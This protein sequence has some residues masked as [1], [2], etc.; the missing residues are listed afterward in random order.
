M[1]G[2]S[3]EALAKIPVVVTLEEANERFLESFTGSPRFKPTTVPGHRSR[4]YV[5]IPPDYL[6]ARLWVRSDLA[7][8]GF[9]N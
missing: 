6:V 2:L 9:S 4:R 7:P 1:A 8:D 5:L 3:P